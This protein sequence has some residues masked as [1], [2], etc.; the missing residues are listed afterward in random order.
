MEGVPEAMRTNDD[1]NRPLTQYISGSFQG[2]ESKLNGV[3]RS[4]SYVQPHVLLR[5]M[6]SLV[7]III[8]VVAVGLLVAMAVGACV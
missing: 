2:E 1:R 8:I 4:I 3:L 6:R 5:R 7:I